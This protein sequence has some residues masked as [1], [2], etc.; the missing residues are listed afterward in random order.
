MKSPLTEK[1][2]A[3][4]ALNLGV[5]VAVIKAVATVESSGGGFIKGSDRPKILFEG[6][7]FWERLE[8]HG[9]D[10]EFYEEGNED[11][12][13]PSWTREHYIGSIGEYGRLEKASTIHLP[14]ALESASWGKFQVMGYHWKALGYES[15]QTFVHKMYESEGAHL[16]S[17]VRYIKAN[18]LADELQRHDWEGFAKKYN[19][20]GYKANAYDIKMANAYARYKNA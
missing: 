7:K 4:A 5:E 14:A 17:F 9:I 19:G 16:D 10:P 13:Y 20:P 11:V 15:I 6:H 12:L 1:D 2:Y 3:R 8:A 18:G